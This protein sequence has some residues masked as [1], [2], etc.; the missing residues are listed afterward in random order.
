MKDNVLNIRG[1]LERFFYIYETIEAVKEEFP[2]LRKRFFTAWMRSTRNLFG[3]EMMSMR[4]KNDLQKLFHNFSMN[5]DITESL[6]Q[7]LKSKMLHLIPDFC[8]QYAQQ[9]VL[10]LREERNYINQHPNESM[11]TLFATL[12]KKYLVQPNSNIYMEVLFKI[13]MLNLQELN[14]S[15]PEFSSDALF[16]PDFHRVHPVYKILSWIHCINFQYVYFY[17]Y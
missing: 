7:L 16:V 2:P 5:Q 12:D 4:Y 9:F 15:Y 3:E 1:S 8:R 17:V 6:A 14:A 11:D 13:S 10:H